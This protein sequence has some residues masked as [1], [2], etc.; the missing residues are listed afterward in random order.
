MS[1][2]TMLALLGFGY[3]LLGRPNYM[4]ELAIAA[5]VAVLGSLAYWLRETQGK[6]R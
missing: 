2:G 1:F 5:V 4:R 3:I 6:A